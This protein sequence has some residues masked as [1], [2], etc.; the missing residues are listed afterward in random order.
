MRAD[1][2]SV[3]SRQKRLKHYQ[4]GLELLKAAGRGPAHGGVQVLGPPVLQLPGSSRETVT[5]E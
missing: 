3:T 5:L 1:G 2:P 4:E